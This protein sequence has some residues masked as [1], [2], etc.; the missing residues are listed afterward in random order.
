MQYYLFFTFLFTHVVCQE[1]RPNFVIVLTDDQDVVLGGMNPMKNVHRFIGNEGTTF[2]NSYVTSP[3]CCPSRASLLTG[4]HVHNHLT[5]NNS[6]NGGCYSRTWRKLETRTFAK[7]LKDS[8]YNTFYAGKYLNEYGTAAA[9]GPEQVPPG[10]TEWHGLVG[11]SAY[12]NYTISNNGVPTYAT[13]LYLTDIIRDLSLSYIEN[14]TDSQ[15]FLMMLAPP[16]PHQPFTPAPRHE[17]AFAN[18]TA[19]RHPNFNLAVTDKH[20][21]ITMPPTPLPDKMLPELDRV[22]RT[23]WQSLLAV[24][25]MLAD[26]VEALD[27]ASL[28]TNTYLIYT[29]DNGYHIGQFSQVYDKRQP[30][31]SD[32]KVP[33]IIRGPTIPKNTTDDQPILNI[34]LAPTIMALAGLMP[35]QSMDGRSI[36]FDVKNYLQSSP[37]TGVHP[38][39]WLDLN[40]DMERNML[41]EYYGEGRGGSVDENC[42]WKY[43]GDNLAEC[44]PQYDCKCQDARNN[45]FACLRHI[46]KRINIKYCS[47]A[48]SKEFIEMY[49]LASDP[50]ELTNI[51]DQVLPSVKHWY[52]LIL[53]QML[54]CKGFQNCDN[55][56]E[57]AKIYG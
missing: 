36:K 17:A 50:Y 35:P 23:R 24:D 43:D 33:L 44:Y 10:W 49:D 34:D 9:G 21:L 16:A 31:E 30:Y 5:W 53:S 25:E 12:Y 3:I 2:T 45:T 42:P 7:A 56:L 1:K 18:I 20:W 51:I 29:S 40:K 27:S 14:Q 37:K 54:T 8:G 11:N 57:N 6:L 39:E 28:L 46:A 55:P 4:L 13:D 32:I 19:V 48:D 41:I 52:Q 15:P 38:I 22:Y 47:F 26:V